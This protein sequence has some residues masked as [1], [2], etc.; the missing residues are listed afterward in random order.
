LIGRKPTFTYG[1]QQIQN[2]KLE[3]NGF[4]AQV[5]TQWGEGELHA[6]LIGKFNLSNLLAV[7]TTLC[8][9]NI[10]FKAALDAIGHLEPVAGRMQALGGETLPVVVVDYAHTPDSLEKALNALRAHCQGKLYCLFGCG[11]DRDKG[12]RPIMAKL[13]EQYADVVVVTDDNPRYE[14][15]ASIVVEI[16]GGFS[17]PDKIKVEHD[18]SKAIKY[19]IQCAQ[20]GDCVLI[21]GRGAETH[22]HI[23]DTEL[24]FSDVEKVRL[25]LSGDSR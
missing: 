2:L 10:D 15:P 13:A 20:A 12:K 21:A 11:G 8:V 17:K 24:A 18:R 19:I 3:L 22:Q 5:S 14:D 23:R 4:S 16:M 9:M 6:A 1:M 25:F 7:L